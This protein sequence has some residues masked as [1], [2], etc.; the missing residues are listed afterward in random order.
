[1]K[2][3]VLS[4]TTVVSL[5]SFTLPVQAENLMHTN[6]LLTTGECMQCDL[7]SVGLV[8]AELSGA[9]LRGANLSRANLSRANLAGA[10]LRGA[11]LTGA[12]LNGANLAGA[13]L[14]GAN[15]SST[16]L[17]DAYLAGAYLYGTDLSVAYIQGAIG[18]PNYVGTP[19]QFNAW[20]VMEANN[21]NYNAA[22]EHYNRSLSL[23]PEFAPA[24]LGRS[25]VFYRLG[26]EAQA[27]QNAAIAS[28]LFEM[29]GHT[30]GKEMSNQFLEK[31][32]LAREA[33]KNRNTG[34]V[35]PIERFL[36]GVGSF[37]LQLL[38]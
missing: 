10:D 26:N 24:Y 13:D 34:G 29:Q 12:S 35:S 31:I 14:S 37:L 8:L 38:L 11:N 22:L 19:E 21:G 18:I 6:Q 30:R 36:G 3:S 16:D 20:G 4:A 5:F 23:D 25:L 17:R 9:N 28:Q 15:L 32:E 7:S 27:V 1:M 33:Q 2:L